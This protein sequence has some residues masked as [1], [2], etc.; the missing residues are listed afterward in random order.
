MV[1]YKITQNIS[2]YSSRKDKRENTHKES[3]V[4]NKLEYAK[5]IYE[6]YRRELQATFSYSTRGIERTGNVQLFVPH[7]HANGLLAY[8]PDNESYINRED[9][10][11]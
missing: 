10:K 3:I 9:F 6:E 11:A 7:V 1:I 4:I 2:E 8:W 5:A